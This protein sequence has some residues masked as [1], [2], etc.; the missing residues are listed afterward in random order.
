MELLMEEEASVIRMPI[1]IC[2]VKTYCL[3][4]KPV[5]F[6]NRCDD[7]NMQHVPRAWLLLPNIPKVGNAFLCR[8]TTVL[9]ILSS[10]L[11]NL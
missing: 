10:Q 1:L 8:V 5:N 7:M 4:G 9:Q 2:P 3:E 11:L 6:F